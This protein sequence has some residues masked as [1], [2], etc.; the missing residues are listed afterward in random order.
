[1]EKMKLRSSGPLEPKKIKKEVVDVKT[2]PFL[3][4]RGKVEY[5]NN[6]IDCAISC[7]KLLQLA[8]K[9]SEDF[10]LGFDME[11]PFSFQTGSGKTALIQIAPNLNTCYL[12]HVSTL[13]KI[14]VVLY[15]LL[16]HSKVKIVGVNIKNDIHKLS[17]DFPGIDSLRIVNNCIDLRPMARSA[18][19]ALS[20]YSM[21][22][23]VNHFL[24]MQ[25]NKSKNV[26]NS[27]WDVVPLSKEQIEYAATDAYV[28][29]YS[30]ISALVHLSFRL[31]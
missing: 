20:S 26:R 10:V 8:N 2:L 21:E 4:Y 18:E 5:Y 14:P 7:D 23:L 25:I 13:T 17:R 22:K 19:Q 28:S 29:R 1:M 3:K 30:L 9:T 31:R 16:S 12:Y 11:W 24:N 6:S 27:K 15:E